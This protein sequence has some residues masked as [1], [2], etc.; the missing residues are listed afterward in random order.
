MVKSP[1]A[2]KLHAWRPLA[3]ELHARRPGVME[4]G[5]CCAEVTSS[6]ETPSLET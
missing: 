4:H 2:Y 1:L 5:Y 6:Q 3:Q